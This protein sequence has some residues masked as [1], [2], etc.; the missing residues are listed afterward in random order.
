[1]D[2]TQRRSVGRWSSALVAVMA[3][4]VLILVIVGAGSSGGLT[5][6]FDTQGGSAAET[7]SV[8]YG[9]TVE[10]PEDVVRPG[11]TLAYWSLY[12]DGSEA[13]DFSSDTVEEGITLYAIWEKA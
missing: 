10:E 12:P 7:Q 6:T 4:L 9:G 8:P 13:W 11:Y 1:M 3:A 2:D 5:V